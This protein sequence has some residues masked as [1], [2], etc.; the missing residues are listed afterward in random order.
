LPLFTII[1]SVSIVPFVHGVV[2]QYNAKNVEREWKRRN[3]NCKET[4]EAQARNGQG[5]E[6]VRWI[7][8]T[9]KDVIPTYYVDDY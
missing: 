8:G 3:R 5:P 2:V 9:R 1:A 4:E 6:I 7:N